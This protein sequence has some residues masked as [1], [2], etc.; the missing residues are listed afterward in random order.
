[1]ETKYTEIIDKFL[2]NELDKKELAQFNQQLKQDK[3]LQLE[4]KLQQELDAVIG[5]EE[6]MDF[7]SELARVRKT[8][9]ENENRKPVIISMLY[10]K[11][12]LVAASVVI[13]AGIALSL[14]FVNYNS[15]SNTELFAQ[16]YSP[17][18]SDISTR[19]VGIDNDN[20]MYKG[21]L[22]YEQKNFKKAAELLQ[23]SLLTKD[24]LN[25]SSQLYLG[26]SY[27]ELDLYQEAENCFKTIIES[28]NLFFKEQ[29]IWYLVMTYLGSDNQE[30]N[31]KVIDLLKQIEA[32]N[33]DRAEEAQK[34]LK[35]LG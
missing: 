26:I 29:A 16:Y 17:Y 9:L 28:G 30:V 10:N 7:R 4:L 18:D 11:T 8:M 32:L 23:E 20:L 21:M 13:L 1:M 14:F 35:N 31:P 19:T 25:I 3:Q 2:N 33:G 6:T 15:H 27:I 34:L 24:S 22:E 12:F 5:D